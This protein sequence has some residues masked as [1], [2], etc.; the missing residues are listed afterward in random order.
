MACAIESDRF[1]KLNEN[2]QCSVCLEVL[3]DPRTLPCLHSFCKDCLEG[4]VKTCRDKALREVVREFNCPICRESFTLEPDEQVADMA[5]NHFICN[6]VEATA[7]MSRGIVPC[8]HNCRKGFSVSRCVTCEKFLCVQCLE[9]HNDY[10]GHDN[11]TVL[12]MEELSKPEN[13]KKISGKMYC[14]EHEGKTLK[15]YCETCDQLICR[16][17]MDFK[18]TKLNHSC[19]L[20]KDV[21]NAHR[22]NVG[23]K[24][25][26]M[27]TALTEGED[28]VSKLS[29]ATAQ[30]DHDAENA[31]SMIVQQQDAVIKTLTEVL[32]Q[33]AETLLNEV[34]LIHAGERA[35]L[36]GQTKVMKRYVDNI[37]R[38]VQLSRNL[39]DR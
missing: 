21:A 34:N 22:E 38:S 39:I 36:D 19:F 15:V 13:R 37:S 2:L 29:V 5:R 32:K 18:H 23:L 12:T 8:S 17:C 31:R 14:D 10:R 3:K 9:A 20:I 1:N 7:L 16:D 35:K 30:L 4:I 6:M 25:K 24:N 27:E 28:Y 11:H 33:K 26:A